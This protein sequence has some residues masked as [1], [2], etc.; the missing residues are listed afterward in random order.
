VQHEFITYAAPLGTLSPLVKAARAAREE[1][2]K[3][4]DSSP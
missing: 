4:K 2:K 1:E 3:K